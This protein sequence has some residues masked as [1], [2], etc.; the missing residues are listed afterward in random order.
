MFTIPSFNSAAPMRPSVWKANTTATTPVN[1]YQEPPRGDF[2]AYLNTLLSQQQADLL[3][4]SKMQAAQ[5]KTKTSKA[6]PKPHVEAQSVKK[7]EAT[8]TRKRFKT[9]AQNA[10]SSNSKSK[11]NMVW[12]VISIFLTI[13]V[14]PVGSLLLLWTL[15]K[16]FMLK[17][18]SADTSK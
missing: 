18:K 1:R 14:P 9:S 16:A 15:A 11:F 2:V 8:P 4:Q 7:S 13:V 10:P 5:N 3:R 17:L 6:L 12:L